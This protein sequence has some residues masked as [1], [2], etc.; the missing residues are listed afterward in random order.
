M[1]RILLQYLLP[2]FLP[3][4]LYAIYISVARRRNPQNPMSYADGPW[5]WA[6]AAGVA[7]MLSGLVAVAML[8]EKG[9]PNAVYVPPRMENGQVVPGGFK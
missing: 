4:A 7:L 3:L 5:V 2:L 9:D 6:V 8:S 1:T